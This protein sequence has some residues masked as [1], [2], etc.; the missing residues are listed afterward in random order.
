M[1]VLATKKQFQQM[2]KDNPH[3]RFVFSEYNKY[4]P[5][6]YDYYVM[7]NPG[8]GFF[9]TSVNIE[10]LDPIGGLNPSEFEHFDYDWSLSADYHDNDLFIILEDED[11]IST[12]NLLKEV[13]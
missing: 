6:R 9:A 11:I 2:I 12:I 7:D 8:K 1:A 3:K 10:Y 5:D 13:I 4:C